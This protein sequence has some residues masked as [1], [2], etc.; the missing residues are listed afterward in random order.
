M[1]WGQTLHIKHWNPNSVFPYL[2]R[3][4]ESRLSLASTEICQYETS[5]AVNTSSEAKDN[6][7]AQIAFDNADN[8]TRTEDG[9]GIFRVMGDVKCVTP[10]SAV[11]S[12]SCILGSKV[13]TMEKV[14]GKFGFIPIFT[15]G[16]LKNHGLHRLVMED[17]LSLKLQQMDPEIGTTYGFRWL[18]PSQLKNL[19]TDGVVSW[20]LR[21]E[22]DKITVSQQ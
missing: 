6:G 5:V 8:N 9:H 22:K 12:S 16:W 7:Y 4:S 13:I 21:Q 15:H 17:V 14:V 3:I 19:K 1:E 18:V 10:S 20:R 11:Q 2:S